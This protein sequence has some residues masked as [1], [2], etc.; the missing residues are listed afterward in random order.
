MLPSLP[1]NVYF[2]LPSHALGPTPI[3]SHQEELFVCVLSW[4]FIPR[5]DLHLN[6]FEV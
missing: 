1:Y 5:S 2:L 4:D 3:F 6:G